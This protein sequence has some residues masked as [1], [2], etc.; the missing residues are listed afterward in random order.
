MIGNKKKQKKTHFFYKN[1]FLIQ[2]FD[3]L[4]K[5]FKIIY[6]KT[7]TQLEQ[8][9]T[10]SA[11]ID[12]H[13]HLHI[14]MIEKVRKEHDELVG[15][16][17]NKIADLHAA[18]HSNSARLQRAQDVLKSTE[19]VLSK[20]QLHSD[21]L[22]DASVAAERLEAALAQVQAG[23]CIVKAELGPA[24]Q[25][26]RIGNACDRRLST[27]ERLSRAT[28]IAKVRAR[29]AETFAP[30]TVFESPSITRRGASVD[31]QAHRRRSRSSSPQTKIHLKQPTLNDPYHY[32]RR[33]GVSPILRS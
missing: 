13:V 1:I 17:A 27:S 14:A 29:S 11:A 9:K 19:S 33:H 3:Y 18:T 10:Q 31:P 5:E 12:R 15:Q 30:A 20:C 4:Y 8:L 2:R 28:L 32:L 25:C 26:K 23:S 24:Q 22:Q 21:A 7:I 6:M 16:L